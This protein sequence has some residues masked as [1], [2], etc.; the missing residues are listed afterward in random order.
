MTRPA[1]ARLPAPSLNDIVDRLSGGYKSVGELVYTI[2]REAI[3]SGAL[4]PGEKLRQEAIAETIGVSRI[5][6]RSALMQLEAEGLVTVVPHRGA[7][8]TMLSAAKV[9]ETF[10]IRS[11]LESQAIKLAI[12]SLTPQRARQLAELADR[13]D[14]PGRTG[15]FLT[16]RVAFY[17][18]LY[19]ADENPVLVDLIEQLRSSV[20]RDLLGL[21]VRDHDHRH[22]GLVDL[23]VAKDLPGARRW[24]KSHLDTVCTAL[25]AELKPG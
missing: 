9:R 10:A 21:R 22:R 23:V 15:D 5:P 11:L 25:L 13:L 6:V 8:V 2:L 14:D 1:A 16:E 19:A 7:M 18:L 24:I 12:K 17:R 4:A 3:L 20:G